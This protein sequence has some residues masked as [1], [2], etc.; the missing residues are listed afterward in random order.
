[1][2]RNHQAAA[3]CPRP[4]T[5]DVAN[6]ESCSPWAPHLALSMIDH[7]RITP[8]SAYYGLP[9]FLDIKKLEMS[10]IELHVQQDGK[11]FPRV[12]KRSTGEHPY[13]M[14]DRVSGAVLGG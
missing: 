3:S 10:T 9:L 2:P 8:F 5:E 7:M 12:D 1:M 4:V 13:P 11:M 6:P 14:R